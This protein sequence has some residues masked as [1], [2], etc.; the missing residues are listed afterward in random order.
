MSMMDA[1][2]SGSEHQQLTRSTFE[3]DA[4]GARG[5]GISKIVQ[6][7]AEEDEEI[8]EE[9]PCSV[10]GVLVFMVGLVSGTLSAVLA[11][12]AYDTKAKTL[13]GE[14]E[15]FQKPICL[16]FLM[17]LGM[18]P[19]GVLWLVQQAHLPPEKQDKVSRSTLLVLIIPCV[20]DL[21]CTLLLLIAQ[22]YITASI[23]QMLRGIV[24]LIHT[25][26]P[27]YIHTYIHRYIHTYLHAYIHT[28]AHI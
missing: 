20:C 15:L 19:A 21:F 23:W 10:A 17:F 24:R 14:L 3:V 22:V 6:E 13:H 18:C 28:C 4:G 5:G 27:T 12:V 7:V 1:P 8:F 11:K 9:K 2:G 16:L 26:L 25:Y